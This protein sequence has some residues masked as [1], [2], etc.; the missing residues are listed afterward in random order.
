MF[1]ERQC[2]TIA[3]CAPSTAGYTPFVSFSLQAIMLIKIN[4]N[5]HSSKLAHSHY[6]ASEQA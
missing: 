2:D 4:T 3:V 1:F 6:R 5:T